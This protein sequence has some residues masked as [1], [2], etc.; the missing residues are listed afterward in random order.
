VA[1]IDTEG[2]SKVAVIIP[3]R[4]EE[5]TVAQVINDTREAIPGCQI[6]V[7]DNNSTDET[8]KNASEAGAF[9]KF[10]SDIGKGNVIRRALAEIKAESYVIIDGDGTYDPSEAPILLKTLLEEDLDMVVGCR[11]GAINRSGH[12]LGNAVFN[13]LYRW[14][15]GEGF[16]D[17]FSGFRVLSRRFV[18]SFPSSSKGF[19]IETEISVHAS[20]LRLPVSEVEVSYRDRPVGSESKLRTGT[21]GW[22]ILRTMFKL[23]KEN[24]P[25]FLYNTLALGTFVLA[26]SLGIPVIVDF[27]QTGVVERLPTAVLSSALIVL[28]LIQ[29]AI[30]LILDTVARS[31]IEMKRLVYL[32]AN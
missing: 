6:W 10:E 4:N 9:L 12:R 1:V 13:R 32:G 22:Q 31:R 20:Q 11:S 30:G 21:D 15:F 19:E 7:Y 5:L 16:N 14:L 23:L 25:L 29:S 26:A 27:S 8:A 24:R 18:V 3:C 17:I 28:S 2:F